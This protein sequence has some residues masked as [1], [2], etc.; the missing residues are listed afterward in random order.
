LKYYLL[1]QGIAQTSIYWHDAVFSHCL[2]LRSNAK[3]TD[4][5][6]DSD[7]CLAVNEAANRKHV[8]KY[9]LN[10]NFIGINNE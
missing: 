8:Q 1:K 10:K 9:M 2:L 4:A 7:C 6:M 3:A 5:V